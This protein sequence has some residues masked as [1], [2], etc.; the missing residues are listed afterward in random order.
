MDIMM[1]EMDGREA[2]RRVRALEEVRGIFSPNNVK[3]IMITA[4]NELKEV[5][6]SFHDLC[7]AYLVKPVDLRELLAKVR[8]FAPLNTA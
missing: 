5:M 2:V 1:P 7:D 8:S 3:I 6:G 4:V